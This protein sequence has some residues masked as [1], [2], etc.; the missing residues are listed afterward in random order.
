MSEPWYAAP[1]RSRLGSQR[2]FAHLHE[3]SSFP[4][5]GNFPTISREQLAAF[6]C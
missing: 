5:L 2:S 1:Q 3:L 4:A 6:T